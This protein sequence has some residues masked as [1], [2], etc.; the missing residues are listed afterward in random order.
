VYIGLQQ[1]PIST[2]VSF[3]TLGEGPTLVSRAVY[4]PGLAVHF[5]FV[6]CSGSGGGGQRGQG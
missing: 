3:T 6:V 4:R 2:R 5:L 1:A